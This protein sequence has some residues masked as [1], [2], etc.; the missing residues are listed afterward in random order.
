M[1]DLKWEDLIKMLP[2]VLK[3]SYTPALYVTGIED[4]FITNSPNGDLSLF[5]CLSAIGD[6]SKVII[7]STE[8]IAYI[9]INKVKTIKHLKCLIKNEIPIR[10]RGERKPKVPRSRRRYK[11]SRRK[12]RK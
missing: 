1:I 2:E 9:M 10:E 8:M 3:D 6:F 11:K 7:V 12:F 4:C 5:P